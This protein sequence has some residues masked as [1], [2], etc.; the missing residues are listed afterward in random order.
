MDHN[1]SLITAAYHANCGGM[2]SS[3][4]SVW[5]LPKPY[6]QPIKDVY[7]HNKPNSQWQLDISKGEWIRYLIKQGVVI[8]PDSTYYLPF[9][10]AERML[11]LP[12][13]NMNI[14]VTKIRDDLDLRSAFFDIVEV[15][16]RIMITGKGYGHGVGLCQEGAM[17]MARL[18]KTFEEIIHYYYKNVT[19]IPVEK[20]SDHDL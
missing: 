17:E 15:N 11:Y 10:Q 18:G 2:T 5:L 12:V 1:S 9:Y 7:C 4:E 19:I 20:I 3:S 16:N 8:F 6:L 14:T 13:D